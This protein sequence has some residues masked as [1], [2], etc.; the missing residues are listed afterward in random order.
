MKAKQRQQ[1]VWSEVVGK[2]NSVLPFHGKSYSIQ[3]N[4]I[5]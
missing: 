2:K 1:D 4:S 5:P 3:P